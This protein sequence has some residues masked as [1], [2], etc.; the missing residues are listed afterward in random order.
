[1][2]E[3]PGV[4]ARRIR[5]NEANVIASLQR[6]NTA[7]RGEMAELRAGMIEQREFMQKMADDMVKPKRG[8][9]AKDDTQEPQK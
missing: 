1:M 9:P 8:R 4:V 3:H 2:S 6:E 5:G 7:L